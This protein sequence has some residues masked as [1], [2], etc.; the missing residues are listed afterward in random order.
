MEPGRN[1]CTA[2][3]LT[4]P[5]CISKTV[6]G[7]Q[8]GH[9]NIFGFGASRP[10]APGKRR[11]VPR[12]TVRQALLEDYGQIAALRT[13]NGLSIRSCQDW[14]AL[15]IGNPV[16]QQRG[17][18]WPIGWVLETEK[19][20]IV[21]SVDNVPLAYHF[22]GRE[23]YAATPCSWAVD[24]RY[25]GYSMLIMDRL[26]KQKGI[27]IFILTTV[28]PNAEQ[29]F[30]FF[31]LSRVPVGMWHKSA[32]WITN[33]R[34]FSRSALSRKAVPLPVILSYPVAA[35]LF[36]LDRLKDVG[37]PA[38]GP[39]PEV[40]PCP[41]FDGRFDDFWEE[42]KQQKD[43]ILLAVRTREALAWH[44]R[45]LLSR[46]SVSILTASKGSRLIAYAIFDRQDHPG[47]GLKRIRLV[48]FQALQGS[49]E[50]LRPALGW[51][52]QRCRDEGV[53]VLE[54]TGCWLDRPEWPRIFAPL[55]RTL[56]SWTYYYKANDQNL[57][58]ALKDPEVWA[59][60]SFD[61]DASI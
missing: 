24:V 36:C 7:L 30:R 1:D 29:V 13:R 31:Q 54:V 27:D 14:M 26:M 45:Y 19:N 9:V 6:G 52:L 25:R 41:A 43:N 51:M 53:H 58:E 37:M 40:E 21:G 49:E 50:V 39:T 38:C 35:A 33:Y 17:G 10:A 34:G 32:F 56:S 8:G 16:Y 28:S 46:Q 3:D 55:R 57:S 61:G 23:L 4:A 18:R 12:V 20:E 60:S 15:W 48:D 5:S 11:P 2:R 44:F 22:R 47:S 42:L 59:P